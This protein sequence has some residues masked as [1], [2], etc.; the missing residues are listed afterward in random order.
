MVPD[1]T[2]PSKAVPKALTLTSS[3]FK[4]CSSPATVLGPGANLSDQGTGLH[5]VKVL[6][7]SN[8]SILTQTNGSS[9]GIPHSMADSCPRYFESFRVEKN[10]L[11]V[12]KISTCQ[13]LGI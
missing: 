13:F 6:V 12:N 1:P 5:C 7:T 4:T 11:Q 10:F 9:G 3:P 2:L 8:P